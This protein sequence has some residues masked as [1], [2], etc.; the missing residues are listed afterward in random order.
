MSDS[1]NGSTITDACKY[2]QQVY[3]ECQEIFFKI[4]N[5]MK[6]EWKNVYG[7]RIT[8]EVTSSLQEPKNWLVEAIFRFYENSDKKTN[9]ALTISFWNHDGA[10]E[11]PIITAGKIIYSDISKRDHWDLWNLW[12][13]RDEDEEWEPTGKVYTAKQKKYEYIQKAQLFSYPLIALR[14]DTELEN[15]IFKPLKKL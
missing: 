7:N 13:N 15:K 9:K 6:P 4:D 3:K 2:L 12:F 5:L 1:V 8:K 11:E 14:D 10:I